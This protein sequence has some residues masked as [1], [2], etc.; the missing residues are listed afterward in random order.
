MSELKAAVVVLV[1]L[2]ASPLARAQTT[3]PQQTSAVLTQYCLTCHN[4]KLKTAG[5]TLEPATLVHAGDNAE[6][7]E[8]VIRKLRTN[9]MPPAGVPR[10][11]Q[12]TVDSVSSYL[13]A[14]LDRVAAE[15]PKPG[16]LPLLHR[17]SRT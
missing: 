12:A 15:K 11:D 1:A 3:S 4:E 13:E 8:K 7:W 16:K 6:L 10:P 14:E 5:F 2:A 17:L 9:A